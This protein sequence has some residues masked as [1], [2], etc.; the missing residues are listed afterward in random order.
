[1]ALATR[2]EEMW[3]KMTTTAK[4]RGFLN[5]FFFQDVVAFPAAAHCGYNFIGASTE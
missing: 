3:S 4:R 2:G 1:M 5:L